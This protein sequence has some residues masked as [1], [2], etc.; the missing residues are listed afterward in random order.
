MVTLVKAENG[1][2]SRSLEGGLGRAIAHALEYF[3]QSGHN[4][5][6]QTSISSGFELKNTVNGMVLRTHSSVILPSKD[7]SCKYM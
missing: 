4:H 6:M 1:E 3:D 2:T 5:N 7:P